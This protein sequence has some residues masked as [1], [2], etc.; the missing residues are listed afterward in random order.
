MI[1]IHCV[2]V[3]NVGSDQLTPIGSIES[4]AGFE[5]IAKLHQS[6]DLM[7]DT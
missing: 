1:E 3:S 6:H 5:E 4:V 7:A 2:D